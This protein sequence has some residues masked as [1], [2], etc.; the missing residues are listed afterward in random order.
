MAT[1]QISDVVV[2]AAFTE[3]LVQ[4]SVEKTAFATSGVLV[5]NAVIEDQLK[6]GADSFTV[7]HWLDLGNDEANLADD[8]GTPSTPYKIG[9]GKQIVRKA[10]LHN[11]WAAMNLASELAGS[12]ALDRIQGRAVAYWDRQTQRRLIASLNGVLTDNVANDSGDMIRNVAGESGD[13]AKFGAAAVIDA[14]GTLGDSMRDLVAIAM[15]SDTYKAALKADLI[16]TLPDSQGGWIQVFRGLRVIVDDGLPKITVVDSEG[17][18]VVSHVEYITVLFGPGA[19]GYGLTEP[20]VAAGTEIENI[21][22]AGRGGGQQILHSRV[23]LAV[24]PLGFQWKESSV[25]GASPSIAELALA[26][27]WDRVIERKAI[28]LAFL[29]H[30]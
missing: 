23:N 30:R 8:S 27:N 4:N 10:F 29:R 1:T 3:Y 17:P 19:V 6:A 9:T 15:H 21:P 20:R 5:K 22:S 18:P 13:A 2:P 24:H 25:A 11:S 28:P 7:P 12:N 16:Q 14:A 26:A